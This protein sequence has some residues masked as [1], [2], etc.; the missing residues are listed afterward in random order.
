MKEN[1]IGSRRD[2]FLENI[3]LPPACMLTQ[4]RFFDSASSNYLFDVL[5][6]QD[7]QHGLVGQPS[8]RAK[9]DEHALFRS[10]V[11]NNRSPTGRTADY[12]GRYHGATMYLV[13]KRTVLM[14]LTARRKRENLQDREYPSSI[15][16]KGWL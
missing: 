14:S 1:D 10:Y 12:I 15:I 6:P 13:L 11:A 4:T 3:I 16:A 8:N 2:E 5:L 7:R 9:V